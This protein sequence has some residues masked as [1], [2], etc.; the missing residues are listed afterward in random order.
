MVRA[1]TTSGNGFTILVT[2]YEETTLKINIT[3]KIRGQ[4][5]DVYIRAI[6]VCACH[7][8][9]GGGEGGC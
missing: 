8:Q 3:L 4:Y 7:E 5:T 2:G 1:I 6:C 9:G